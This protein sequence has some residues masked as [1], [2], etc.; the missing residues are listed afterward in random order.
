[1]GFQH[2]TSIV[3]SS[4]PGSP[5]AVSSPA[6]ASPSVVSSPAASSPATQSPLVSSPVTI[7]P[8]AS[9]TLDSPPYC[10]GEPPPLPHS[11]RNE[12]GP[13]LQSLHAYSDAAQRYNEIAQSYELEAPRYLSLAKDYRAMAQDCYSTAL[14]QTLAALS[15]SPTD[16]QC[17]A[18]IEMLVDM[19]PESSSP[20]DV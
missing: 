4:S 17:T 9:L 3:T 1:M 12:H 5:I 13:T 11:L 10:G 15:P 8:P 14:R 6:P 7:S 20:S 2:Q 18:L 19:F 16:E